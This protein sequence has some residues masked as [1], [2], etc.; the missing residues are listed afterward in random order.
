[1]VELSSNSHYEGDYKIRYLYDILSK[2]HARQ[3]SENALI[4]R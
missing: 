2:T 3:H 4:Q 1:M